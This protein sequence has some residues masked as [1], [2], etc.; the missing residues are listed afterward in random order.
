MVLQVSV[1]ILSIHFPFGKSGDFHLNSSTHLKYP[2]HDAELVALS[3]HRQMEY[4]TRSSALRLANCVRL[5]QARNAVDPSKVA[6]K[7]F[8]PLGELPQ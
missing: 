7:V 2:W 8:A 6:K 3:H 4:K 5:E 1:Q